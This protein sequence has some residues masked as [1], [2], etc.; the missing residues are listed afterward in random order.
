[1]CTCSWPLAATEQAR[2]CGSVSI[3]SG[4]LGTGCNERSPRIYTCSWPP[5]SKL[6]IGG[7]CPLRVGRWV[8]GAT[9]GALVFAPVVGRHRARW[10]LGVRVHCERGVKY[11]VQCEEPSYFHLQ[12][13]ATEQAG[14]WGSVSKAPFSGL[15]EP[16]SG[17]EE[18]VSRCGRADG[19][20]TGKSLMTI[21][22]MSTPPPYPRPNRGRPPAGSKIARRRHLAPS[23]GCEDFGV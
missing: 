18:G 22:K 21:L 4:A 23:L 7:P 1:M 17:C 15:G 12:L 11:R 20:S 6:G 9:K 3:A 14:D 2:D 5:P 19:V 8:Q 16:S 10:G 13:A